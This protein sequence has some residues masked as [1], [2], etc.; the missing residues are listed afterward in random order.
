MYIKIESSSNLLW[1]C[2]PGQQFRP[3]AL[4][5]KFSA[6]SFLNRL[7]FFRQ[8]WPSCCVDK[9]FRAPWRHRP[10]GEVP[11]L[12]SILVALTTSSSRKYFITALA[13]G[14][15]AQTISLSVSP[16]RRD[17]NKT[18]QAQNC[19]RELIIGFVGIREFCSYSRLRAPR[20][21]ALPQEVSTSQIS[22]RECPLVIPILDAEIIFL[23]WYK[24]D[25]MKFNY[26][27]GGT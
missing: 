11:Q 20:R 16:L 22:R 18:E 7:K 27:T 5:K 10:S 6:P 4:L 15:G 2:K 14:G 23:M 3:H 9:L 25:K 12:M 1:C 26:Q 17:N 19:Y 13:H 8:D 24:T 21:H